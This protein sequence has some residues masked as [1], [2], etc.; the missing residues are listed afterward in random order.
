VDGTEWTS[1]VREAKAKLKRAMVLKEEGEDQHFV[2]PC[3]V[4]LPSG[5]LSCCLHLPCS[6]GKSMVM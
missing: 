5:C 3:H 2:E 6:P 1:A 4:F